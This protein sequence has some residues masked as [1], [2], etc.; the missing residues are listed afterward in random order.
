MCVYICVHI[1]VC[2]CMHMCAC[3][4]ALHVVMCVCECM[5]ACA[6]MYMLVYMCACLCSDCYLA[7]KPVHS[8]SIF[9]ICSL[10][11]SIALA[12]MSL[13]IDKQNFFLVENNF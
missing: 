1:R 3:I 11:N 2:T 10:I 12:S 4:C 9:L 8:T 6:H 7:G 13:T 5:Y